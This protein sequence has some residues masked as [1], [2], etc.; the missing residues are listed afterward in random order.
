[1]NDPHRILETFE[2]L[3]APK[4]IAVV[5]ASATSLAAANTFIRRMRAFGYPGRIFPI[6]PSADR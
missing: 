2:P 6:H 4:T 3:I 5:G 1:M